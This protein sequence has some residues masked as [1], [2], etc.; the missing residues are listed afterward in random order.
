MSL[1]SSLSFCLCISDFSFLIS[2]WFISLS[3]E[4]KSG[5]F[6]LV[7]ESKGHLVLER[8]ENRE[9]KKVKQE[10]NGERGE[11]RIFKDVIDQVCW[12]RMGLKMGIE[13]VD[14]KH[15]SI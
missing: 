5:F 11:E 8:R 12:L 13:N 3:F 1:A 7:F 6:Y 2:S 10:Q 15:N 14:F 9:G 4:I